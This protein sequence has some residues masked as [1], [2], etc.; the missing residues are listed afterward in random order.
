MPEPSG[1]GQLWAA[2]NAFPAPGIAKRSTHVSALTPTVAGIGATQRHGRRQRL[3]SSGARGLGER[4]PDKA[5]STRPDFG[6]VPCHESTRATGSRSCSDSTTTSPRGR[7]RADH[8]S[9]RDAIA[10]IAAPKTRTAGVTLHRYRAHGEAVDHLAR[11]GQARAARSGEGVSLP[12]AVNS[13]C[14]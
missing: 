4:N 6:R 5:S 8:R 1:P 7:R 10:H 14:L 11:G 2:R 3:R 9:S 13:R 12:T